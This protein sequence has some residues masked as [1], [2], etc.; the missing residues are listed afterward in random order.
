MSLSVVAM[1]LVVEDMKVKLIVMAAMKEDKDKNKARRKF[2]TLVFGQKIK[3][4]YYPR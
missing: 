2:G 1:A 4:V 3:L